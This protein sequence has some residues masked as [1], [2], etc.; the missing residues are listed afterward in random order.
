MSTE[1]GGEAA[2]VTTEAAHEAAVSSP[3]GGNTTERDF[4]AEAAE[5]GWRPQD[6][7]TGK[8]ENWK[9]A[10]TWVE[11]GEISSRI[12]KVTKEHEERFQK[13]EKTYTKAFEVLNAAHAKEMADLKAERKAAIK[14]GDADKVDALDTK[15]DALK[16]AA[17]ATEK[18][19]TIDELTR[20]F[21]KANAWY[22]EEP[23]MAE[24]AFKVSESNAGLNDGISFEDNMKFV[25]G[26]VR[27]KFP[28]YFV[29]ES[30]T[31]AANGHAAV[32]GGGS[33]S[34]ANRNT[35]KKTFSDLP[36]EAKRAWE[37]FDP[38]IKKEL[39]KEQYAKEYFN[40]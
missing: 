23:E 24:Y 32:D 31:T 18:P 15:I 9:D 33:F 36:A 28:G 10:K 22:I 4:E 29:G 40:A 35:D 16:E 13:L 14:E 26:A 7:W 21:A 27:K 12:N 20:D 5:Q 38:K 2:T 34:G 3:E 30:E 39:P 11:H 8:P 6:E 1:P 19:K 37:G 17:P 25:L